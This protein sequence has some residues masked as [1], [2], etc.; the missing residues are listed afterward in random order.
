MTQ[1]LLQNLQKK[2]K[3]GGYAL[4]SPD[5]GRVALFADTIKKLYQAIEIKQ[6]QDADKVVMYIPPPKVTHA[7][8]LSLSVRLR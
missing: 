8:S 1:T 2:Y 3:D 4:V 5:T 7:F 6:I